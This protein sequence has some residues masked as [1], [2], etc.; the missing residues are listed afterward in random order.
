VKKEDLTGIAAVF[1]SEKNQVAQNAS[2]ES[3]I[4]H[5]KIFEIIPHN[6]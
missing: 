2:P 4:F 5:H 1:E 6:T 3:F